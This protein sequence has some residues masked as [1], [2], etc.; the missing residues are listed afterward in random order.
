MDI[1]EP[2]RL[3]LSQPQDW[4]G[5]YVTNEEDFLQDEYF[6]HD[7]F[8]EI[9]IDESNTD[10]EEIGFHERILLML[11]FIIKEN[12]SYKAIGDLIKL[13]GLKKEHQLKSVFV[14][15][16]WLKNFSVPPQ[17]YY[18]CP[19]ENCDAFF[20]ES[21]FPDKCGSCNAEL[22]KRSLKRNGSY[23]LYIPIKD[24]IKQFLEIDVNERG[25]YDYLK[26]KRPQDGIIRDIP[27]SDRYRQIHQHMKVKKID[28]LGQPEEY[29]YL[30]FQFNLDGVEVSKSAAN[31]LYPLFLNIVEMNPVARKNAI[32]TPFLFLK[33]RER[34]INFKD[35][36]LSVFI[37]DCNECYDKGFTWHSSLFNMDCTTRLVPYCLN[38]DSVMKPDLNGVV[39][40][41]GYHSC[42]VCTLRG[43]GIKTRAG[44]T[45]ISRIPPINSDGRI[46]H[47]PERNDKTLVGCKFLPLLHNLPKF[48]IYKDCSIDAMHGIH[49]G[50]FKQLYIMLFDDTSSPVYV[51]ASGKKI[52]S[53]VM[54]N[55]SGVSFITRGPR[56]ITE[57]ALWKASEWKH[58]GFFYSIA[59]IEA[60]MSNEIFADQSLFENW[61]DLM[62]GLAL[63]NSVNISDSDL[64]EARLYLEKFLIEFG[65]VYGVDRY[66]LNVHLI[67]HLPD[68]VKYLGP[69]WGCS[70]YQYES[71]NRVIL[72]SFRVGTRGLLKQI[73]ERCQMN[74]GMGQLHSELV[75]SMSPSE[76]LNSKHQVAQ[77]KPV[78]IQSFGEM[79]IFETICFSEVKSYVQIFAEES[80]AIKTYDRLVFKAVPYTTSHY[81][82]HLA[83]K[84]IDCYFH[85]EKLELFGRID[86]IICIEGRYFAIFKELDLMAPN[87]NVFPK[88]FHTLPYMKIY[89]SIKTK[90]SIIPFS[91]ISRKCISIDLSDGSSLI[92]Y[93]MNSYECN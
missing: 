5:E 54:T 55:I 78:S 71:F 60:L 82:Q 84:K 16:K 48:D 89:N 70:L 53:Q 57:A 64:A 12:I 65:N 29:G 49:I 50:V 61:I 62:S 87:H 22:C 56:N 67:G 75:S 44:G 20:E 15:R 17:V 27:D 58:W 8:A 85:S 2:K 33:N 26:A 37:K 40:H 28:N 81:K 69:L 18:I 63:L 19:T 30:T 1:Y 51:G 86:L 31:S 34:K 10:D 80:S 93:E 79:E 4:D 91:D 45:K 35:K 3:K 76:L 11:S 13:M 90:F 66:T 52:A 6:I 21:A 43:C 24:L 39:P 68:K 73:A 7:D 32:L 38:C 92:G 47:Q 74:C 83:K 77:G 9:D 23:F 25:I 41:G 59:V 14:F 42:P 88:N 72:N 46:V 36:Y